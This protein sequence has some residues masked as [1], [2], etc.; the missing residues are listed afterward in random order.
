MTSHLANYLVPTTLLQAVNMCLEAI[1]G[2]PVSSLES[3]DTNTDAETAINRIGEVSR[4]VQSEGWNWNQ[5]LDYEIAPNGSNQCVLPANTLRFVQKYTAA[6]YLKRLVIRAGKL[7][8]AV[9]HTFAIGETAKGD[10]TVIIDFEDL[11]EPARD[12]IAKRAVRTFSSGK[13]SSS[14]TYQFTKKDEDD[15][16][17]RM[18]QD[19]AETDPDATLQ[20]NPHIIRL[21]RRRYNGG[22]W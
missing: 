9:L 10:I 1:S 7:Y 4:A 2:T 8:D 16:R 22:I 21:R 19:A 17:L 14:T 12:Y 5:D 11:P 18:E 3:I 13:M 20:G 15:A 6:T